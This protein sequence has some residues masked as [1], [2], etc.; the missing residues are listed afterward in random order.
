MK[1]LLFLFFAIVTVAFATAQNVITGVVTDA[2]T[3]EQL[4][5][6]NIRITRQGNPKA[7]VKG[8]ATDA[9][10][11]FRIT[12]IK[13]GNYDA[14][15]TIVGYK[16]V[17]RPVSITKAAPRADLGTIAL[18]TS[19]SQLGEAT[20]TA[21]RST[22]KLEVDRK[23]YNIGAD[24]SN[25]GA[26]ASEALENIPSVEVDQDGNISMRG[27]SSVEV[28]INGKPSGLNS[29]NRAM[30]LQQLPAETIDRIEVIDNP[31][32]KYSAE[33]SA[34]I[35]NIV[36]KADR[37]AGYYGSAQVGGNTAGGANASA[38]ITYNSKW[39]DANATVGYRHRQ[40]HSGSLM[41]QTFLDPTT[42]RP[43]S[44][45]NSETSGDNTGNNL[46]TRGGITIHASKKDDISLNGNMMIGRGHDESDT[47]YFYGD[48][49]ADGTQ[50]PTQ[51]LWRNSASRMPMRMLNGEFDY[52][53]SF[54]EK[55]YI[56][57]NVT[58]GQWK[59]DMGNTYTDATYPGYVPDG[60]PLIGGVGASSRNFQRTE[61][62]IKNNFTAVKLDYENTL[63]E[64]WQIQAGYNGDFH[65]E[66]TPQTMYAD[67]TTFDGNHEI[68][69]EG[70]YNRFIYNSNVHAL[71]ATATMKY[72]KWGLQAGLR[73]EY[74]NTHTQSFN[75]AQDHGAAKA[76]EAYD[77]DFFQLFPSVFLSYQLTDND[78]LQLNYSRRLRRP[79]GG[80]LNPFMDTRSATNLM[81][82]NPDLTP[83]YSNAFSLN[84]LRTWKEGNHSMLL[85]A[86]YRPT[87]DVMQR[88]SYRLP[89]DAR[90]ELGELINEQRILTTSQNV[91]KSTSTGGEL[92]VK[93]KFGMMFDLNTTLSAYYYHL[94]AFDFDIKDPLY[95][96]M[97]RVS[98]DE[99]N[100]FTWNVRMQANLRLPYDWSIQATGRYR[101]KQAV[102]QG[103][104]DPSYGL[105]MGVRKMFLNKKLILAVN[106]RDVLN[107]HRFTQNSETP[108]FT[109]HGEFWRHSRKVGVTL[110]WNFG[111]MQRKFRPDQMRQGQQDMNGGA[112][113]EYGGGS[114]YG[115]DMGD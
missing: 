99:E 36:L 34:G 27:S 98:G 17:T 58:R 71:Y 61:Q 18:E 83:E 96:Q 65:R 89:A 52:R 49:L 110:T 28:W 3:G 87:N 70:Y 47:P 4:P 48:I 24:L 40:D 105:D 13:T 68:V 69:D 73:G 51:T 115:V 33:G 12:G 44:Y 109:Q 113:D 25:A 37:K 53:H 38:N 9:N 92:T 16:T 108:T 26:S 59:S 55:H 23:S 75:Y 56:S 21:E 111:N 101:S 1:R 72:G 76:P 91:T 42:G 79:W 46:F 85:S 10:G 84:Y 15:F 11:A 102:S 114:G 86:F 8:D 41:E 67:P 54:S 50:V 82:G 43:I 35:I 62:H 22:M 29:D 32:A 60:H 45:Q 39:I 64:H 100:R 112:A 74:W 63:N 88:L 2:E 19:T 90:D 94:D 106:C 103:Y 7:L 93:N 77:R 81:F 57:L 107:S 95:H 30:I 6:V 97:V 78:Q 104:R 66:N 20:V 31:S 14:I 80:E 5:Y